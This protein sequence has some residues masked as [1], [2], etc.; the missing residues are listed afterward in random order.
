[1]D[2]C[3]EVMPNPNLYVT[4]LASGENGYILR[5]DGGLIFFEN[6]ASLLY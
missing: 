4:L 5:E 6:G 3:E 1:M 2:Y